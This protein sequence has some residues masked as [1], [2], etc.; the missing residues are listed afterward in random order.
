[1][2]KKSRNAGSTKNRVRTC[3]KVKPES[4]YDKM[5]KLA[6]VSGC[7]VSSRSKSVGK[8]LIN[9]HLEALQLEYEF[10]GEYKTSSKQQVQQLI[11]KCDILKEYLKEI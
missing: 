2:G 1:M 10:T 5:L 9:D 6:K 11:N 8:Q 3:D 7:K 4:S